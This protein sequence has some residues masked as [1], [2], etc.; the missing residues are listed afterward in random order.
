MRVKVLYF[1]VLRELCGVTEESVEIADGADVATLY[2]H[3]RERPSNE[4]VWGSLA[5]AVN[6][7]YAAVGMVLREGDEVALLP[8][9]SGGATRTAKGSCRSQRPATGYGD[10]DR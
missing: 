7:E 2:D 5:V 4:E 8:P 10:D 1:G 3:L 6:R 9:V